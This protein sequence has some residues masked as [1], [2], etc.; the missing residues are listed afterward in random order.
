MRDER[1]DL[2]FVARERDTGGEPAWH[3]RRVAQ[4][5]RHGRLVAIDDR[6]RSLVG[7]SSFDAMSH[8]KQTPRLS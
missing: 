8:E 7:S 1:R 6:R 5:G 3:M 2:R 4:E